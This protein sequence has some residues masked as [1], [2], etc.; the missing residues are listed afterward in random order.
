MPIKP[1]SR[2][3]LISIAAMVAI[4]A[5]AYGLDRWVLFLRE[6]ISRGELFAQWVLLSYS[7]GH[8]L[9]AVLLLA[10]FVWMVLRAQVGRWMAWA[11]LITGLAISLYPAVYFTPIGQL[12]R[13]DRI[14]IIDPRSFFIT[15]GAFLAV[16][17]AVHLWKRG[18]TENPSTTV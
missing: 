15:A 2:H 1:F 13:L 16:T 8:L 12:L 6:A 7:L 5:I 17:G 3:S 14:P 10:L 18:R 9:L 4:L 11:Y